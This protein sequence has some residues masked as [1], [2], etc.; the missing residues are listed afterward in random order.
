LKI[1]DYG[2]LMGRVNAQL[3]DSDLLSSDQI[4]AGGANRVRGFDETVGYSNDGMVANLEFQS[5]AFH[6]AW[7]GDFV[8]VVFVDGAILQ[9]DYPTDPGE[10]LSAG[11][12]FLW[13]YQDHFTAKLELGVPLSYP[14]SEDGDPLWHFAI[15]MNW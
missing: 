15:G 5:R 12:G 11:G 6:T 3:A 13:R 7:A 9:R 8:A 2:T 1:A 10:L 14:D 4:T